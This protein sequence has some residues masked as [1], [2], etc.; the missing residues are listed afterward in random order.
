MCKSLPGYPGG[1]HV[2]RWTHMG[3]INKIDELFAGRSFLSAKEIQ[4]CFLLARGISI[5]RTT[6]DEWEGCGLIVERHGGRKWYDWKKTWAFYLALGPGRIKRKATPRRPTPSD[7]TR[8][9]Q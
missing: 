7:S 4:H 8:T 6:L 2:H 3:M 1:A 5:S 9:F